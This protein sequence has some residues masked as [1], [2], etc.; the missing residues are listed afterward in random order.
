[1]NFAMNGDRSG[2][3]ENDRGRLFV[4]TKTAQIKSLGFRV[5][6]DVVV[7]VVHVREIDRCANEHREEVGRERD[8][9][10]RHLSGCL[11]SV[12]RVGAKIALQ[13]NYRCR[14]I[15]RRQRDVVACRVALI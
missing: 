3:I 11:W 2:L 9:L 15:D 1:M 6:K 7:G 4:F 14:W 8:V 10:L 12:V 5:G 13:I